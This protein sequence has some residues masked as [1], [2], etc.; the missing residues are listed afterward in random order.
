MQ[1]PFENRRDIPRHHGNVMCLDVTHDP[2]PMI[3]MNTKGIGF[4]GSGFTAGETVN[5]WLVSAG[6]P[7]DEVE[8][9]CQVVSVHGDRV[10]VIFLD[11][12]EKLE[13]FIIKH[14]TDPVF[15]A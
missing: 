15:E 7:R 2:M 8:T 13:T 9:L 4:I 3:D 6:D 5:L 14:I 1:S 11:R 12:T 10:A